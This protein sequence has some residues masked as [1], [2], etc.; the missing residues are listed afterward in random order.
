M[1]AEGKTNAQI[2][3]KV[4]EP[5]SRVTRWTGRLR[6]AGRIMIAVDIGVSVYRIATASDVDRPRVLLEETGR[7]AGAVAG[8]EGGAEVGG[9]IGVSIGEWFGPEGAAIGGG[10]GAF[11]GGIIGGIEGARAGRTLAGFVA[12]ELYPPAQTGLEGTYEFEGLSP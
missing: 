4:G 2:L 9:G 10:I 12:S 6:I 8:A 7:L 5:N 1:R 11:F 3:E